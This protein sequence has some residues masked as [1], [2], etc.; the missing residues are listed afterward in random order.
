M[1]NSDKPPEINGQK[2]I[3]P[4]PD[5]PNCVSSLSTAPRQK[6]VALGYEG[7]GQ[8][9]MEKLLAL[10]RA[11]PRSRVMEISPVSM[12][13]EFHTRLLRFRDDVTFWLDERDKVIHLRSASR[14]GYYDFGVNRK[15][16]LAIARSWYN[17]E[18]GVAGEQ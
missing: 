9:A 8:A 1:K 18:K 3:A 5:S 7:D 6:A 13:V 16:A 4:C 17:Q 11:M 15:R 2:I 10:I 14:I 12:R